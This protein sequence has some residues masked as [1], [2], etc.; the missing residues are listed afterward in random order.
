MKLTSGEK[1]G[2]LSVPHTDCPGKYCRP[3]ALSSIRPQFCSVF[4]GF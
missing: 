3:A 2:D 4:P 1:P